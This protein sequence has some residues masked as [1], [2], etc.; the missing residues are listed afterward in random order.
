MR[1][2]VTGATGYLGREVARRSGSHSPRVE[3]LDAEA[4]DAAIAG[5]DAVIHTAYRQDDPRVN[6]EGSANVARAAA[7]HGA[8][9]V[10]LSSDVVFG[11]DLGRA[12]REEDPPGPVTEYGA[13]KALAEREVAAACPGAVLVRTSLIYGGPE[14]SRH[15]QLALDPGDASFYD[16]EIRCPIAVADLAAA[17][18]ELA[19]LPGVSGP[20]HVAGADAVSRWEFACLVAGRTDLPR[21]QRPRDRPG[22]LTLDCSRAQALLR[23]PLRG[24]REVLG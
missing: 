16:D 24:V 17:V 2:F 4:V 22:D 3:I 5:C 12:L 18:L 19:A 21:A 13:S 10:H 6:A 9:L 1:L 7:A 23:T 11:G 15:E 8:R 20:L 14:P